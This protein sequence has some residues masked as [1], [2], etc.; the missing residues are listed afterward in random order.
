MKD[1]HLYENSL[2]KKYEGKLVNY[3]KNGDST[4]FRDS[5]Y[6]I[7]KFGDI[8]RINSPQHS[9]K[10]HG[11]FLYCK[12]LVQGTMPILEYRDSSKNVNDKNS[13]IF[14]TFSR[15]FLID[16]Y[17]LRDSLFLINTLEAEPMLYI[18]VVNTKLVYKFL[19]VG[20]HLKDKGDGW[21]L[22]KNKKVKKFRIN[23]DII[24]KLMRNS[25]LKI[26]KTI[27]RI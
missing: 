10:E 12:I 24:L 1:L 18:E 23:E 16:L 6:N 4:N 27:I 19:K 7:I 26:K 22:V 3:F 2:A 21:Y 14:K 20:Y 25:K 9:A 15:M 11:K 8:V 5:K 17:S 13:A